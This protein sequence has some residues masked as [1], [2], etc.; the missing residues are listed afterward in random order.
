MPTF[1]RKLKE[2]SE[3]WDHYSYQFN[4]P[5]AGFSLGLRSSNP[6]ARACG[7]FPT[8][9]TCCPILDHLFSDDCG[10]GHTTIGAA[11]QPNYL[12]VGIWIVLVFFYMVAPHLKYSC[13]VFRVI[14]LYMCVFC[15]V[16]LE[17]PRPPIE[18]FNGYL[19]R[20]AQSLLQ[21]SAEGMYTR[22]R[23]P[24]GKIQVTGGKRL[25]SSGQYTA[26][27]GHHVAKLYLKRQPDP[28]LYFKLWG[29]PKMRS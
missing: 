18:D 27:F 23:L 28:C 25:T 5:I 3:L 29:S 2:Y 1:A 7:M 15:W 9:P 6:A 26:E 17:H 16:S 21:K 24:N 11:S 14:R 22:K 19:P 13:F 4:Q 8:Y 12:E 20:K 10:W